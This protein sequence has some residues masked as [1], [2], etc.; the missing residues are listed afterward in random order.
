MSRLENSSMFRMQRTK[1]RIHEAITNINEYEVRSC[2]KG[3]LLTVLCEQ[4]YF[5][6]IL[7]KYI[8]AEVIRLV[9]VHTSS[10]FHIYYLNEPHFFRISLLVCIK[11]LFRGTAGN[12]FEKVEWRLSKTFQ[13]ST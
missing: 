6:K 1:E 10:S 8:S 2:K 5:L 12:L 11:L 7:G 4:R 13:T 3:K 9:G